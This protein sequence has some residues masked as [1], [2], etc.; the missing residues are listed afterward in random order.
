MTQSQSYAKFI[1]PVVL[2]TVFA[3]IGYFIFLGFMN[4]NQTLLSIFPLAV[5]AGLASFFSPCSFPLLP[6]IVA[7]DIEGA[8]KLKPHTKGLVSAVGVLSFLIPL[9]L[10]IA[11][12]GIPLGNF[13]Q[14]NL[15]L[16]RG[17][18]GIFLL[19]L[20]YVQLSD[21][22]FDFF[23]KLAPK[24]GKD[25]KSNY[26]IPYIFGFGYVMI[27]SGCTV[28]IMAGLVVGTLASSGFLAAI[29]SFAIAGSV[30]AILMF[31][32]MTYAGSV[33]T[34]PEHIRQAT[35]KIKKLSGIVLLIIGVF[36]VL[37]AVYGIL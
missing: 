28:P 27:G 13:L 10:I 36:Y 30:M 4:N 1:I 35:P 26:R 32:F 18:V 21:Y 34:M 3:I 7:M 31:S 12:I 33:K 37:N 16:I 8:R 2:T 17:I 6:G 29:L 11:L 22:H 23:E 15:N 9:G 5:V 20:G 24:V 14:D 25:N 19:Y